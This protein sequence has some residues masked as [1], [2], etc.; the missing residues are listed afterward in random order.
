MW[1]LNKIYPPLRRQFKRLSLAATR[2]CVLSYTWESWEDSFIFQAVFPRGCQHH[3][4]LLL[5]TLFCQRCS[6]ILLFLAG[7]APHGAEKVRRCYWRKQMVSSLGPMLII[8]FQ[9]STFYLSLLMAPHLLMDA[10]LLRPSA[11]RHVAHN[12]QHL[13]WSPRFLSFWANSTSFPSL[14]N[15]T[16]VV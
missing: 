13:T 12:P 8:P 6:I 2:Q 5:I 10:A 9:I 16:D 11:L 7:W 1:I 3:T 4:I 14:P 15:N